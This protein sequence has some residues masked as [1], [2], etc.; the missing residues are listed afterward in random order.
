MTIDEYGT[1]YVGM[2]IDE[3]KTLLDRYQDE[4]TDTITGFREETTQH[5][6]NISNGIQSINTVIYI[7]LAVLILWF[8]G[9]FLY[10]LLSGI[11]KG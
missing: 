1:V 2:T 7:I 10:N 6:E 8:V 11:F 3:L 9:K 4:Q 5:L